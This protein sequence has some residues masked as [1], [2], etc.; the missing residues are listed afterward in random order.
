V[1][2]AMLFLIVGI[3]LP[4]HRL[5]GV[6]GVALGAYV[7]MLVARAIPVY[8]L[9]AAVDPRAQRIPWA[10]RHMTLWGGLRGALSVALALSVAGY[11]AINP[12]VSVIA[13]GMVVLSLVV[14]GGLLLP[15]ASRL[16][17]R[18]RRVD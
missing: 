7:I 2:N 17:L 3:A 6:A 13:Y 9:L 16:G 14:Q 10:W 11:P 5:L 1:L 4:A 18:Q 15:V 12:S 8:G